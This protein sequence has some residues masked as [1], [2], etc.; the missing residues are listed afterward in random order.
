MRVAPEE[1][2]ALV[3]K[4]LDDLP[5]EFAE[6]LENVAVVVEDEPTEEDL[7]SV[8]LDPEDDLLGL[9]QGV[10]L[11]ERDSFYGG[12]PDRVVIYRGPILRLC[13]SRR[14]VI[15]EVRD[16]VVHELGHHFG[17]DEDDMPY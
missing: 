17:L 4:A 7:A 1:F 9:Y 16:T 12:L 3:A 14:E 2:E 6:L 15:R 8:D 5:E 13:S 11:A 10:P